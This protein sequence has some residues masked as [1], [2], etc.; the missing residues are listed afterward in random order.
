MGTTASPLLHPSTVELGSAA[1]APINLLAQRTAERRQIR[2]RIQGL[3]AASYLVDAAVLLIYAHAGTIA[4]SVAPAFAAAGLAFAGLFTLLSQTGFNDRFKDHYL[5]AP[6]LALSTAIAVVFAY[7]VP[8]ASVLFLCSLFTV[9]GV[10]LLRATPWQAALVWTAMAFTLAGMFL[11]TDK[12]FEMPHGN[13]LERVATMLVFVLTI[14]RCI[15]IGIF[16]S[17][18][19]QSL[20]RSGV[21]LKEAYRRIEELAE[22]DELTGTFNRRCIMRVVEEQIEHA[23][24][25]GS[26][27]TIALIDLD[28]FKRINDAY[29]HP[30]GDEVLRTFAIT[31]FANVRPTDRFGRYGGEEFLLVL[32]NTGAAA[33]LT[34]L[35]RL[36]EIVAGIDWTAFSQG[37]QVTI[38]AGVAA[39]RGDETSD[40]LLTRADGALYEAKAKGRNRIIQA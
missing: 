8:E 3:V 13:Y 27:C 32:P 25:T 7:A 17:S 19:R 1:A 37:M 34:I 5:P 39:L 10:G 36:R 23:H 30:T 22:L 40:S 33:A 12:P 6:Q 20:Y 15:F 26:P 18:M 9:F 29:G 31:V 21:K 2:R 16:S 11:L 35:D 24:R 38:S 28:W 14:G 4:V